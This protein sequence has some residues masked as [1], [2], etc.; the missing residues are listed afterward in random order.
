VLDTQA[1]PLNQ[2]QNVPNNGMS[3]DND[4]CL[5]AMDIFENA[6]LPDTTQG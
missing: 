1:G 4:I 5:A 6:D 3:D 2:T